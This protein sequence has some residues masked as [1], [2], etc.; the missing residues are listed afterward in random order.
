MATY[1]SVKTVSMI[2]GADLRTHINSAVT[3]NNSGRAVLTDSATDHMVGVVAAA[4][5]GGSGSVVGVAVIGGGGIMPMRAGAAITAGQLLIPDGSTD[6]R[7]SGVSQHRCACGKSDG[8][9]SGP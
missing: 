1:D 4:P 7:V 9:R 3:V 8:C 2:A 6:G 5:T